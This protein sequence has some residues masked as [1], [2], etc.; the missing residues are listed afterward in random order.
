MHNEKRGIDPADVGHGIEAIEK[1]P[2]YGEN[3]EMGLRLRCDA[4]IRRFENDR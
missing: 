2:V 1:Q 3:A 4:A